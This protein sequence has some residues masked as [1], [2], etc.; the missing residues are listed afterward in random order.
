MAVVVE[1]ADKLLQKLIELSNIDLEPAIEKACL[2]VENEAKR[3]CP[4][5]NGELRASITHETSEY[6]GEVGSDLEYAPYVEY[7]TGV[8]SS[9][10]NGRKTPWSY[11]D[12][13]GEWHTT[14]GQ[15]PQPFLIPALEDKREEVAKEIFEAIRKGAKGN[16]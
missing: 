5:D 10:G 2:L 15:H 6:E 1:N 4:V 16:D 7:G 14:I 13:K 11:R 9:Q 8:F 12:A 3:N